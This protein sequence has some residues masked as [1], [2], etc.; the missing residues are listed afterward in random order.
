MMFRTI[1]VL[2]LAF[3]LTHAGVMP[4]AEP[5]STDLA[6]CLKVALERNPALK[7]AEQRIGVARHGE[8]AAG[9]AMLP[10][11]T[12]QD[13]YDK[14]VRSFNPLF[15]YPDT[16]QVATAELRQSVYSGGKL[17]AA[18]R[19]A[20]RQIERALWEL[21]EARNGVVEGVVRAYLDWLQ[22]D[23]VNE[24]FRSAIERDQKLV[25]EIGVRVDAGKALEA[26]RLQAH[27]RVLDDRRKLLE[28]SNRA[29]LAR[30][31]LLTHMDLPQGTPLASVKDLSLLQGIAEPAPILGE[32]NAALRAASAS[33][34]AARADLE[35]AR[36]ESRPT[37]DVAVRQSHAFDGLGFLSI[38]PDFTD[39]I[40][41]ASFP[42]FDSGLRR[43]RARAAK[44]TVE[45][46][47]E[48]YRNLRL[49]KELELTRARLELSEAANRLAIA[50]DKQKSAAENLRVAK[51][52]YDAGTV[53]LSETLDAAASVEFAATEQITARFDVYRAKVTML[54]LQG[55]MAEAG[56]IRSGK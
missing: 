17:Q 21:A 10:S 44:A 46:A 31:I 16:N 36:G 43:E 53:L 28:G 32:S 20:R 45:A 47:R 38:D 4:A 8:R 7:A 40:A 25:N 51:E 24:Y 29:E 49:Q 18:Q 39:Y 19:G 14:T 54:R 48:E 12:L 5:E 6:H 41:V 52:R 55:K 34:E 56:L 26:D 33:V 37:L 15:S 23:E 22:Q 35:K 27:I 3:L 2:A 13:T 30:S 42:L 50:Q 11:I 9:A 1:P